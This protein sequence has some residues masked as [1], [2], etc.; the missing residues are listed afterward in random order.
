MSSDA[1]IFKP[2]GRKS[3]NFIMR[4]PEQDKR[5]TVLVGSVR[6]SKT[7]TLTAKTIVQYSRYDALPPNAKRLLTGATKQTLFRNVL[8]DLFNAVGRENYSYNQATG[9]MWLF[10]KQWF[11]LGAKDE[12][13]YRQILGMTVGL[14]VGDEIVEYPESFLAQLWLRMSPDGARFAGSTNPSNPYCYLKSKMIDSPDFAPDLEVINFNLLKD[15][16]N[17][18]EKSKKKIIASQTGVYKLRYIDGLWVVADGAIYR[19]SW[20][21]QDNC[22]ALKERTEDINGRLCKFRAEPVGLRGQGGHVDRWY[23]VDPGVDHPQCHLEYFDDGDTI[24]VT[25]EQ[26]WDSRKE[27]KQKTDAQYSADLRTFMGG[28]PG[29]QV[30]VPPEAASLKAQLVMDGFWVTDADNSV[31]E[32]IHT[33]SSMLARRKLL[34]SRDGCPELC[35]RIPQYAWDGNAAKTGKEQPLKVNDDDVDSL[36]YGVHGHIPTWRAAGG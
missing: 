5:Y 22:F 35:K 24:W 28:E 26:R 20:D 33:V 32:G 16:P 8:G 2:F 19:D 36:R 15:N 30:L 3:W 14:A 9:E 10:G 1:A 6:S 18:S 29:F 4:S 12:A 34:V 7:F 13:S 31:S 25:R 11:C 17:L 21:D 23:S 27:M